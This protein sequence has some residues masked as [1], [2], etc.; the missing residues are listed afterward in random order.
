MSVMA[1]EQFDREAS[2]RAA[3]SIIKYWLRQGLITDKE[4][5][6]FDTILAQRFSPVW[7]AIVALEGSNTSRYSLTISGCGVIDSA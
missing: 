1:T 7:G 6:K 3:L 4:Y 5:A 2:Y